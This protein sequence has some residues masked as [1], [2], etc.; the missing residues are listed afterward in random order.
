MKSE[1]NWYFNTTDPF[2]II[3]HRLLSSQKYGEFNRY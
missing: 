3:V 2:K 1:I